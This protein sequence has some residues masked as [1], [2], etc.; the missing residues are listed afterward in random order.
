M[1]VRSRVRVLVPVILAALLVGCGASTPST[2]HNSKSTFEVVPITGTVAGGGYAYWQKRYWQINFGQSSVPL[3]DTAT[4]P[5]GQ[6]I[7]FLN[8][9]VP[10]YE[11]AAC[12]EPAGR[13]LYVAVSSAENPA[14]TGK[15]I[16]C[17]VSP[18]APRTPITSDAQAESCAVRSWPGTTVFGTVDG[19]PV[20][21]HALLTV[22]KVFPINV[23]E[24][25]DFHYGP[26]GPGRAAA[27]GSGLLLTGLSPGTHIIHTRAA[28]PPQ[29]LAWD[30][31]FTVRV[32]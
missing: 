5:D 26:P 10:G 24:G 23:V 20:D 1:T 32:A 21:L 29:H 30:Y 12:T 15:P 16:T 7:G 6:T 17:Q 8:G 3:C 2:S 9:G 22:T 4:G 14:P 18:T 19:H 13:A 25:N 31:T 27:Y 28:Y 11:S